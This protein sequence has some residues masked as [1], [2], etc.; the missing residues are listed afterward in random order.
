MAS[1]S[2]LRPAK[3]LTKASLNCETA[4]FQRDRLDGLEALI[5][6]NC[7]MPK[8]GGEVIGEKGTI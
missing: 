1:S 2:P 5:S 3:K 6:I 4:G 7:F 8:N